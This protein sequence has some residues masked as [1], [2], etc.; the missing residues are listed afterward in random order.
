[1]LP[2]TAPSQPTGITT[3]LAGQLAGTAGQL[4][5]TPSQIEW[6]V[7][8]RPRVSDEFDRVAKAFHETASHQTAQDRIETLA[9]IAVLEEKRAEVLANDRAGYYIRDWQELSGRVRQIIAQDP[10]Y[11]AIRAAREA[12]RQPVTSASDSTAETDS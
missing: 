6:A 7:Q 10:R 12:R 2:Q 9:L 3:G 5:G 11:L 4:V 8:I 1:M